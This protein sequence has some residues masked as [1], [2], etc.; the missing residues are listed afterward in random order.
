MGDL[1]LLGDDDDEEMRK[2][3]ERFQMAPPQQS[4]ASVGGGDSLSRP[5]QDLDPS[6]VQSFLAQRAPDEQQRPY[7]IPQRDQGSWLENNGFAAVAGIGDAIFNHGR[8]LPSIVNS[9]V[10]GEAA[11]RKQSSEDFEADRGAY[12][13]QGEAEARDKQ[14]GLQG[15]NADMRQ[16]ELDLNTLR[17][18]GIME[19]FIKGMPDPELTKREKEAEIRL[20]ESQANEND[21]TANEKWTGADKEITPY[22]QAQLDE[23]K[24][25][26]KILS[27][28]RQTTADATAAQRE[29][30]AFGKKQ[31]FDRQTEKDNNK[32]TREFAKDTDTTRSMAQQMNELDPI[33]EKY[34]EGDIP[35]TGKADR[36]IPNALQDYLGSSSEDATRIDQLKT[37]VQAEYRHAKTGAA[38]SVPEDLRLMIVNGT[39]PDST[40][41]EFRLGMEALKKA[42]PLQIKAYGANREAQARAVLREQG[43]EKFVYGD[44]PMAP[45]PAA[46]TDADEL[47][48]DRITGPVTDYKGAP[49]RPGQA[50]PKRG[51]GSNVQETV[52]VTDEKRGQIPKVNDY[53]R[54][55]TDEDD[56]LGVVYR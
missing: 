20:R 43:L 9:T 49:S 3:R 52:P 55:L 50:M 8:N 35:G 21:A 41:Q 36:Y 25:Y 5:S 32:L 28:A 46:T 27:D 13:K 17:E 6:V 42:L 16:Q 26:H 10:A 45:P 2:M 38:A 37:G 18:R 54:K 34:K 39:R 31:E 12:L 53:L 47:P 44:S 30:T 40:E 4:Y 19:R 56:D 33:L 7:P 14:I 22:Q 1:Y 51:Y 29:A 24:A 11:R 48:P 23:Q 15:R